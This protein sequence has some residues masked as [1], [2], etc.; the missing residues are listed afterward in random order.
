M[1]KS[2]KLPKE[3]HLFFHPDLGSTQR[4][5]TESGKFVNSNYMALKE[6]DQKAKSRGMTYLG[7][8]KKIQFSGFNSLK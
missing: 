1:K 5:K 7:E 3:R 8:L 4:M 2:P 6:N